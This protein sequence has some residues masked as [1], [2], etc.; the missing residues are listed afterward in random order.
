MIIKFDGK[1]LEMEGGMIELAVGIEEIMRS[2][3]FDLKKDH[4][5]LADHVFDKICENFKVEEDMMDDSYSENLDRE[6]EQALEKLEK[7]VKLMEEMK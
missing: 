3:Y 1:L 5:K 4:P 6:F 2:F 7:L